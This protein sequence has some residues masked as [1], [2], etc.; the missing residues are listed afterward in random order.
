MLGRWRVVHSDEQLGR[1]GRGWTDLYLVRVLAAESLKSNNQS[2]LE[3]AKTNLEKFQETAKGDLDKRQ[4]AIVAD[5]LI[6]G[7]APND[8]IEQ[9]RRN[10][11][12]GQR[13]RSERRTLER[14]R[15]I[16][17]LA[18][19]PGRTPTQHRPRSLLRADRRHEL[20]C[21]RFGPRRVA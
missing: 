2:F 5:V 15:R 6:Y 17:L 7:F 3:L 14:H 16:D 18:R 19:S 4:Q 13:A 8:A 10:V 12:P 11:G 1:P 9:R 21:G 20:R